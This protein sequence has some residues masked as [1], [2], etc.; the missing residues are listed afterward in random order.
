MCEADIR[1]AESHAR[2][3]WRRDCF[4]TPGQESQIAA[5]CLIVNSRS[6]LTRKKPTAFE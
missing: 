5:A 4:Q 2:L 6:I 1:A 3:T